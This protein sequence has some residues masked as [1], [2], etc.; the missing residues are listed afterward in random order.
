[1]ADDD[2]DDLR[3]VLLREMPWYISAAVRFQIAIADQ[4]RMPLTDVH[5]IGALVEFA[6]IGVRRLADLM[7]MTTGATTRL[8]DRLEQRGFVVREPDPD[9]RRRVVLRVVPERVA[10]VARYFEAMGERWGEQLDGYDSEQLR[11]LVEFLRL[12]RKHAVEETEALRA[13]GRAHGS[14]RDA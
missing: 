3:Q 14:R 5:A 4:L 9:D 10:D 13:T 6:P 12:G 1:M 2:G 7:G 8:V 11:F